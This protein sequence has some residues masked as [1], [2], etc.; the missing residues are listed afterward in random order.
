MGKQRLKEEG[1]ALGFS[2]HSLSLVKAELNPVA[3]ILPFLGD[4]LKFHSGLSMNQN[5]LWASAVRK[6][7]KQT[8]HLHIF[9]HHF[10]MCD[11]WSCVHTGPPSHPKAHNPHLNKQGIPF[12][13]TGLFLYIQK[14]F[15]FKFYLLFIWLSLVLVMWD[16]VPWPGRIWYIHTMDYWDFPGGANGKEPTCQCRRH[17]RRGFDPWVRKISWRKARQPTP[18]FLPGESPWTEDPGELQSIGSHRMGHSWVP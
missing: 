7:D 12:G 18:G 1:W 9:R 17:K 16:L 6:Q 2:Q 14:T 13:F 4:A 15:I 8:S 10:L 11:Q 5:L 3:L